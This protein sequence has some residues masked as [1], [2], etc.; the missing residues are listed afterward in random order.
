MEIM[1]LEGVGKAPLIHV[2]NNAAGERN[3]LR[4]DAK[5]ADCFMMLC[6]LLKTIKIGSITDAVSQLPSRHCTCKLQ[7]LMTV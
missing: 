1:Q 3:I 4:N 7:E 5:S 2:I 6:L